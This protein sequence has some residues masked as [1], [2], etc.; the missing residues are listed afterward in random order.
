MKT[1]TAAILLAISSTAVSQAPLAANP[2]VAPVAAAP[3]A[4]PAPAAAA[5]RPFKDVIKDATEVPGF[6]T[7]YQKDEKVWLAIKPEQFGKPFF[8]SYNIPQ[9]V[10]ER[11]L[12]GSQMGGAQ[13]GVFRK[14]GQQV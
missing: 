11:G 9:S 5:P 4:P 8:F 14:N 10:G 7:V 12:Y 3:V 2:A 13:M 6:F 1:L